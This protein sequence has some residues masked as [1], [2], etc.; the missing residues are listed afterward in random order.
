MSTAPSGPNAQQFQALSFVLGLPGAEVFPGDQV[1]RPFGITA[2]TQPGTYNL[3]FV[4]RDGLGRVLASS[5]VQ[6]IVVAAPNT[7]FDNCK[8]SIII[9]PG[10]LSTTGPTTDV[11]I[12]Q[13]T[14]T[15][16]TTWSA[17]AYVLRLQ[18]G[19]KISLLVQAV[20]LSGPVAPGN[21]QNMS[22]AITA[23]G[24]GQ[25]WFSAQMSG[26]GGAFG[27]QVSRTVVCR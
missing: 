18:R 8:I 12:V 11:V 6:Q 4:L 25:G 9:A 26:I 2:P 15:G 7:S 1:M 5:P 19:M 13:V 20:Q 14:N 21:M 3:S 22:F 27:Q 24:S 16:S 17:P 10:S 23:T